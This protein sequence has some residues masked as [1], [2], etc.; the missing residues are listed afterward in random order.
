MFFG[1]VRHKLVFNNLKWDLTGDDGQIKYLFVII[2]AI[3]A[4]VYF[5]IFGKIPSGSLAL[6]T[7][8]KLNK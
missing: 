6:V 7:S 3:E 4:A 2:E 1:S 8:N 5:S